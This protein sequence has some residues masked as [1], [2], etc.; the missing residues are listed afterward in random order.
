MLQKLHPSHLSPLVH[1]KYKKTQSQLTCCSDDQEWTWWTWHRSH[2]RRRD[3]QYR[4]PSSRACAILADP[5][6]RRSQPKVDSPRNVILQVVIIFNL[7]ADLFYLVRFSGSERLCQILSSVWSS[8][9]RRH[10][11]TVSDFI[12]SNILRDWFSEKVG[13]ADLATD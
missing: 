3:T 8:L 12:K 4:N 6:Y 7:L 9:I 1:R 11:I 10:S 13:I 2:G 5:R